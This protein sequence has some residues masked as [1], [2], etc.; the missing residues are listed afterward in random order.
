MEGK[1]LKS[2]GLCLAMCVIA[3]LA[4]YAFYVGNDLLY[5][6]D[7]SNYL[8]GAYDIIKNG[9]F[10]KG[11][12]GFH[13]PGF[14]YFLVFMRS[15]IGGTYLEAAI[16]MN[17]IMIALLGGLLYLFNRQLKLTRLFS[18]FAT[19]A[20]LSSPALYSHVMAGLNSEVLYFPLLLIGLIQIFRTREVSAPLSFLMGVL[21]IIRNMNLLFLPMIFFLSK[22]WKKKFFHSVL[23]MST[24]LFNHFKTSLMGNSVRKA[25]KAIAL[26][27][28]GHTERSSIM[29]ILGT[30]YSEILTVLFI[31]FLLGLFIYLVKRNWNRDRFSTIYSLS[32]VL[33]FTALMF[34]TNIFVD[35]NVSFRERMMYHLFIAFTPVFISWIV[36]RFSKPV[37]LAFGGLWI[38]SNLLSAQNIFIQV[39]R[40]R[41][42]QIRTL[43]PN[44]LETIKPGTFIASDMSAYLKDQ[45]SIEGYSE[46]FR[47]E[48]TTKGYAA[49]KNLQELPDSFEALIFDLDVY[50]PKIKV[51]DFLAGLDPCDIRSVYSYRKTIS[52]GME[53][54]F[55][56]YKTKELPSD[57]E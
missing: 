5:F 53:R 17:Y 12:S 36:L 49:R 56:F 11:Y 39:N 18:L 25:R 24:Y 27:M 32:L 22:G 7:G 55:E 13:P 41:L 33:S 42:S 44:Y 34:L 6:Q 52:E 9:Y 8:W 16:V 38:L 46:F 21:S 45:Y 19:V 40:F 51:A 54:R 35:P 31:L 4:F 43:M 37:A 47:D 57:C 2:E 48:I 28:D 26:S 20:I 30:N 29:N 3:G 10:F 14:F 23:F 50:R 1:S 15:L